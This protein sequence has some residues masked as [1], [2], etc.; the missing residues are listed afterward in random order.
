MENRVVVWRRY[1][2]S[3]ELNDIHTN[4][5]LFTDYS[6]SYTRMKL[7][8]QRVSSASVD[9]KGTRMGQIGHGLLVYVGVHDS[10]ELSHVEWMANKVCSLRI[11]PDEE[12]KMNRSVMD[13]G[14]EICMVSQFT[15]YADASKGTRPSFV[16]AARPEHAEPIYEALIQAVRDRGISV[17]TGSFGAMMEVSSVNSGPVTILLEKGT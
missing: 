10:D 7:V 6:H 17:S 8:V 12:G 3:L 9:V 2:V 15:L 13:S 14:G 11:F 5:I 4:T 1:S 16:H